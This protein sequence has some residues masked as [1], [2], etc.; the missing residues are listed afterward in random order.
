M[1]NDES[2]GSAIVG[3]VIVSKHLQSCE[4]P[5]FCVIIRDNVSPP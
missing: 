4:N 3:V 2:R 5:V 1:M